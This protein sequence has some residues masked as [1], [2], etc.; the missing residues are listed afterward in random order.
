MGVRRVR[1][2]RWK[3]VLYVWGLAVLAMIVFA[4]LAGIPFA[5]LE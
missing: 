3:D 2:I 5:F 4:I 1:P